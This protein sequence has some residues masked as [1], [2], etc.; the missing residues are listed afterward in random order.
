ME[1]EIRAADG[2]L[3]ALMPDGRTQPLYAES[4]TTIFNLEDNVVI[5]FTFNDTG[6]FVTAVVSVNGRQQGELMRQR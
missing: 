6:G 1:I 4:A 3:S 2:G 5:D